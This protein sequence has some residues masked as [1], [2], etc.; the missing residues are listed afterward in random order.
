MILSSPFNCSESLFKDD[1]V[2]SCVMDFLGK[3]SLNLTNLQI[4]PPQNLKTPPEYYQHLTN[5]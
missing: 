3:C 4:Y 5:C 1:S 2:T